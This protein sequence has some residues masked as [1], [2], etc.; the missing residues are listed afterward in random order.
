M[1]CIKLASMS[2]GTF[3]RRCRSNHGAMRCPMPSGPG[4]SPGARGTPAMNL[5]H[6]GRYLFQD[7][8]VCDVSCADTPGGLSNVAQSRRR[9]GDQA[10]QLVWASVLGDES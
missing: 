2:P 9:A 8:P 7:G 1:D 5:D 4:A 6:N 10:G 3:M